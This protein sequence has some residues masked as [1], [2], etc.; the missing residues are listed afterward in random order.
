MRLLIKEAIS[1]RNPKDTF[2]LCLKVVFGDADG[3]ETVEVLRCPNDEFDL[4]ELYSVIRVIESAKDLYEDDIL[5]AIKGT[6]LEK[7]WPRDPGDH[8]IPGCYEAHWIRYFDHEG[9]EFSVR[10][11]N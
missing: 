4:E 11:E 5:E 6:K 1:D 10:V 7:T 2:V 3:Y 8:S 9:K